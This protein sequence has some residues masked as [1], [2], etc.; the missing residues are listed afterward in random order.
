MYFRIFALLG[1]KDLSPTHSL[2]DTS[3]TKLSKVS[4]TV[5]KNRFIYFGYHNIFVYMYNNNR[6]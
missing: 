1:R 2:R 6:M 3:N 4:E 5:S